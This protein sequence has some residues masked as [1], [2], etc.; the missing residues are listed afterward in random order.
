[1]ALHVPTPP[2]GARSRRA[3]AV[4]HVQVSGSMGG[5]MAAP[6]AFPNSPIRSQRPRPW[7][8][9]EP[10]LAHAAAAAHAPPSSGPCV[11]A[12]SLSRHV[13]VLRV[14]MGLRTVALAAVPDVVFWARFCCCTVHR[15]G[16]CP[17][18]YAV[19]VMRIFRHVQCVDVAGEDIQRCGPS[20][21]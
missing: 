15:V 11:T 3:V 18:L 21:R 8:V 12:A 19:V 10:A 17:H 2:N 13:L 20:A 1:M 16:E 9:E 7:G 14:A 6:H 5:G 4:R